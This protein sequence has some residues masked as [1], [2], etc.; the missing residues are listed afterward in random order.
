MHLSLMEYDYPRPRNSDT[1]I[2][3]W[4]VWFGVI[5]L[6][7]ELVGKYV[8]IC[9]FVFYKVFLVVLIQ[10]LFRLFINFA[11]KS[12]FV[13]FIYC[14]KI[15]FHT[16]TFVVVLLIFLYF[17]ISYPSRYLNVMSI[18]YLYLLINSCTTVTHIVLMICKFLVRS[19]RKAERGRGSAYEVNSYW[20]CFQ[21]GWKS[22]TS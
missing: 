16:F 5:C 7:V 18:R 4:K 19:W 13:N 2:K 20:W 10:L 15:Q 3:T 1:K 22:C 12:F 8:F 9:G 17:I 21:Y 11:C 14:K 6:I